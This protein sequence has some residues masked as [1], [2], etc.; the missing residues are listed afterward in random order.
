MH[1]TTAASEHDPSCPIYTIETIALIF[2]VKVDT[3][4]EYTYRSDFPAPRALGARNLWS[5]E[6]VLTWFASLPRRTKTH[7]TSLPQPVVDEETP[8]PTAEPKRYQR[9]SRGRSAA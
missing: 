2:S 3:A 4:R 9:R 1:T 5:R 6:E 7:P 8:P